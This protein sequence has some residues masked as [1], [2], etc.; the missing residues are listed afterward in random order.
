MAKIKITQVKSRIGSNKRQR[1]TLDT[2]GLRRIN[3]T[4]ER[5]GTPD[6]LGMVEKVKHLVRIEQ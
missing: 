4:V 3:H 6:V 2:L 5:E 1:A